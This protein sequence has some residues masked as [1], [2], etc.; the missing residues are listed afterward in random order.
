MSPYTLF[1]KKVYLESLTSTQISKP[2]KNPETF[3][4]LQ[5]HFNMPSCEI[6]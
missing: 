3:G 2:E 6:R 4:E 5:K 1:G